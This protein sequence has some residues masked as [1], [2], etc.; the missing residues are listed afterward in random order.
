MTATVPPSASPP[1]VPPPERPPHRPRHRLLTAIVVVLLIAI[2]AGYLVLSA[3]QSRDSGQDKQRDA[4]APGLMWRWPSKVERRVYELPL[5]G[6]TTYMAHYEHNSWQRSSFYVQFRTS[7]EGLDTFLTEAGGDPAGLAA[8]RPGVSDRHADVVGWDFDV[9]G[10]RYA[11]TRIDRPGERPDLQITVDVTSEDRPQ[12][13][14][15]ST[16][17]F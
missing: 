10:H 7:P 17:E 6:D 15:V 1:A 3:A 11:G 8:G 9:P 4:A 16:I 2:P 12:V 5:P 14:V 13:H